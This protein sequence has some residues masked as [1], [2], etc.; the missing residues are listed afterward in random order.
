MWKEKHVVLS[1]EQKR[2][3]TAFFIKKRWI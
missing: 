3:Q 2:V 1:A